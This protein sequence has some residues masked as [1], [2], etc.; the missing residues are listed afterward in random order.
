MPKNDIFQFTKIIP[1][2]IWS[3]SEVKN[4]LRIEGNYDDD[5]IAS[6]TDAAIIAAENF[7]K[8]SIISKKLRFTC[9]I[10]N[11]RSFDLKYHPI[12]EISKI[13]L[14]NNEE[15]IELQ[16]NKYCI[17]SDKPI[18]YL[19]DR[20][21]YDKLIVEYLIGF[22]KGNIP[23]SIRHGVLI[24]IA[25]MYDRGRQNSN[26]LSLEIKNLYLPYRQPRI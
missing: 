18:L 26:I 14:I 13:S 5:L 24:H 21:P 23:Q 15:E 6:L 7:T 4:Y 11:Q 16:D 1:Q 25:E 17:S 19:S 8:L 2:T 20:F 10:K 9:N 22:N 12:K 3:L